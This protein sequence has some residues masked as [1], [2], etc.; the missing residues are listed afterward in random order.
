[1]PYGHGQTRAIGI[2]LVC[3]TTL[4]FATLDATAKWLVQTL[5]VVQLVWLRFFTH[6]LITSALLA[7]S[8]GWLLVRVHSPR[9]QLLRGLM[10]AT[11]T[12]LNFWALQYL[13][14]AQTG[15]MQFSVPILISVFSVWWL[16]ERLDARRWIAIVVGFV[17]VLLIIRPSASGFHPAILLSLG[18]AVL[19]ALFNMMTRS[20]ARTENAAAT[21][22][23]SALVPTILLMPFA[24]W[25]W[26]TP[27]TWAEWALIALLGLCGGMGHYGLA[28]AH[29]HASAAVLA[30]FLYQQIIY[31]TLLGWL[32]FDQVP[33]AAVVLGSLIV[34]ASG[35]Y[36]LWRE[37]RRS[38]S[39]P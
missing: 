11:M 34:V 30:P 1:M 3:T 25:Q 31:M 22:L 13:Q 35:L 4:L 24:L 8:Q 16:A 18:N 26:Q 6:V 29:R 7:P 28:L 9:L 33:D 17:G 39:G 38:G 23:M 5:P 32:V 12:G 37:V 2:A 19:Y 15:A 21:Q 20:M 14:L 36:L 27:Q 10:L